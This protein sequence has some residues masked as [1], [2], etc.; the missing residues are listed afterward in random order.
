MSKSSKLTSP[1][2]KINSE[3]K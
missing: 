2:F 1:K 3:Q